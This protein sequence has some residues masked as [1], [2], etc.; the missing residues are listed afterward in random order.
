[1]HPDFQKASHLHPI[2]CF[3]LSELLRRYLLT[4]VIAL[5]YNHLLKPHPQN[6]RFQYLSCIQMTTQAERITYNNLLFL[7]RVLVLWFLLLF[8]ESLNAFS[9][10][11][12]LLYTTYQMTHISISLSIPSSLS[13]FLVW[14]TCD[15]ACL[16][17][18]PFKPLCSGNL[19]SVANANL[20]LL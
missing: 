6:D 12:G 18:Q 13:R 4:D 19:F 14:L 9:F 1:M 8:T 3:C 11:K 2:P 16:F 5:A 15:A 10:W 17:L 7:L 20:D